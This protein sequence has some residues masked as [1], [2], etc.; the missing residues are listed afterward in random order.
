[1][2]L[3]NLLLRYGAERIYIKIGEDMFDPSKHHCI[4]LISSEESSFP[5]SK[6]RTIVRITEHGYKAG[7]ENN[8][9]SQGGSNC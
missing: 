3:D 5:D 9:P 2:T 7:N 4:S 1:V 6:P 8:N